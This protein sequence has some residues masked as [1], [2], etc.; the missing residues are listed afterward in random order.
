[1]TYRVEQVHGLVLMDGEE[2]PLTRRRSLRDR[3]VSAN[4][5]E[6]SA[7]DGEGSEGRT[8]AKEPAFLRVANIRTGREGS[9][10][11]ASLDCWHFESAFG[12]QSGGERR[13]S[14]A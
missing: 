8:R 3:L 5:G 6:G 13:D 4:D 2:A 7:N 9:E 14:A 11:G 12:R 10:G 1:M